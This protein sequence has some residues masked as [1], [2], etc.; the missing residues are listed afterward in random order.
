[1]MKK[2]SFF[3]VPAIFMLLFSCSK[4]PVIRSTESDADKVYQEGLYYLEKGD[5]SNAENRFMKVISDF[6]YSKYEPFAT[7]ALGKTYYKKE[8]YMSAITVFETFLKRHP[9]HE[10]APEALLYKGHSYLAQKP[11]DFFLLPNP[12]ERDITVVEKAVVIYR[13]YLEKYPE[14]KNREEGE[15]KLEEAESI[16]IEKDL[17]IAE[18]Y[19]KRKKCAGVFLR[20]QH[21]ESS[22]KVT[23]DKNLK[24]IEELNKKCPPKSKEEYFKIE[25]NEDR[26]EEKAEEK[27]ETTDEETEK[28]ND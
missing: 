27:K 14:D 19:A 1:M 26:S 10:S 22:F 6:S 3:I 17:R 12:A 24:R 18:F 21:I 28:K 23:T 5:L 25:N 20:L 9:N 8:E 15:K 2:I 13:E 7:V 11:S 4:T 16:L